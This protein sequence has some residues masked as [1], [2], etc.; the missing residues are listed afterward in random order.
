MLKKSR[1]YDYKALDKILTKVGENLWLCMYIRFRYLRVY[2]ICFEGIGC[3][4]C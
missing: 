3:E 2:F 4:Y 1:L